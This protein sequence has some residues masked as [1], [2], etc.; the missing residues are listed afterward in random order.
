MAT[1]EASNTAGTAVSIQPAVGLPD[2]RWR[3]YFDPRANPANAMTVAGIIAALSVIM[4]GR[5]PRPLVHCGLHLVQHSHG[6]FR[7]HRG[8]DHGP[9]AVPGGAYPRLRQRPLR[10][11]RDYGRG[12]A[13]A[14]QATERGGL[15]H[16]PDLVQRCRWPARSVHGQGSQQTS[17]RAVR[18]RSPP[19][20][21]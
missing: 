5:D 13:A 11:G 3:D 14:A 17:S 2:F 4:I 12:T 8:P 19:T 1:T 18:R 16:S 21:C 10:R 9:Q 20:F 7:R 15:D 6:P